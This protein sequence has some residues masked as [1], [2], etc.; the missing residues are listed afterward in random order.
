MTLDKTIKA[1]SVSKGDFKV[2][3]TAGET[4]TT[5]TIVDAYTSNANGD[6]VTT[7]S[8][9]VTVEMAISPS[10]GSPFIWNGSAWRNNWANPYKLNV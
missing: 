9:I 6:K 2:E 1:D 3:Q 7:D 10:E 5:R 8:N 4:T